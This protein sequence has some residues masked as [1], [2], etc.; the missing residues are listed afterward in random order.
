MCVFAMPVINLCLCQCG[1]YKC[2]CIRV[3]VFSV[4]WCGHLPVC[5]SVSGGGVCLCA[6][7]ICMYTQLCGM[8]I[9]ALC[10]CLPAGEVCTHS[11]CLRI[12]LVN[13][14]YSPQQEGQ[15]GT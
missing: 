1:H 9:W 4:A 8:R 11:V 6:Q 13:P 2:V 14:V 3:C 10:M 5:E 7:C 15:G 12:G